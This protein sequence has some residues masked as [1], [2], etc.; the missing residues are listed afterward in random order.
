MKQKTINLLRHAIVA[1]ALVMACT[2]AN[3]IEMKDFYQKGIPTDAYPMKFFFSNYANLKERPVCENDLME[4]SYWSED[5]D[6]Y[7]FV[8][9]QNRA[10]EDFMHINVWVCDMNSDRAKCVFRQDADHYDELMVMDM[11]VVFDKSHSDS[12]YTDKK[13][14]QRITMQH[15][16]SQP[17][18]VM[19]TELYTGFSHSLRYTLLLYPK[20]C[21]VITLDL[22][23]F[24]GIMHTNTNP[25]MA[26]EQHLAQDYILTTVTGVESQ[27]AGY[28]ETDD[29]SMFTHQYL[30]PYL[31]IYNTKGELVKS[32]ELPKD[33]ID[34]V[35]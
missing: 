16:T 35:R 34:M 29:F 7:F 12:V 3:A 8:Q 31:N 26:A 19:K 30:T 10:D 15:H 27:E 9:P 18:I 13:T 32:V 33:M 24:V 2:T 1:I 22:E 21:E 25:L 17:V 28:K 23:S 11:D 14:R 6:Y 5:G 4:S 20:S